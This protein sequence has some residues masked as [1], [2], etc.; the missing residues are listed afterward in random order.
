ME[1]AGGTRTKIQKQWLALRAER[2][3]TRE[4]WLPGPDGA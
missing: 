4:A 1:L 3:E 2:I